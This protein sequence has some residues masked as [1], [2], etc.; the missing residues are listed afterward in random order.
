M[1]MSKRLNVFLIAGFIVICGTELGA[2]H[3]ATLRGRRIQLV[4]DYR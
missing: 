4:V 3:G 1:N 2:T